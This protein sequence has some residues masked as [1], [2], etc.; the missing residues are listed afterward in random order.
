MVVLQMGEN[1]IA[2]QSACSR[3]RHVKPR[4]CQYCSEAH[5]IHLWTARRPSTSHQPP[6]TRLRT[7]TSDGLPVSRKLPVSVLGRTVDLTAGIA[8]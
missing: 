5:D 7:A 4:S 3:G 8:A 1:G 6:A 2:L